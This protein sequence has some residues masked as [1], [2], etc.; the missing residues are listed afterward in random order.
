MTTSSRP[1]YDPARLLGHSLPNAPYGG[2]AHLY[3]TTAGEIPR[4]RDSVTYMLSSL[5]PIFDLTSYYYHRTTF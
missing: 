5:P 2:Y 1:R 3:P 4:V